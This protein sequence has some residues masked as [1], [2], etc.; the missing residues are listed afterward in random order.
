MN[1]SQQIRV[2][3]RKQD[4]KE[5]LGVNPSEYI[6]KGIR[7]EVEIPPSELSDWANGN[8]NKAQFLRDLGFWE[9]ENHIQILRS[10]LL[11]EEKELPEDFSLEKVNRKL[12]LNSL[13]GLSGQFKNC[14]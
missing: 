14:I 5:Y 4:W 8:L 7:I 9:G 2:H 6:L 11:G 10:F 13:T 3:K 1:L 12:L